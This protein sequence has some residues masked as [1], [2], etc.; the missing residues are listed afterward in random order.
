MVAAGIH[1]RRCHSNLGMFGIRIFK[2]YSAV[3]LDLLEELIWNYRMNSSIEQ[4]KRVKHFNHIMNRE[5][6]PTENCIP[7]MNTWLQCV[8]AKDN[9]CGEQKCKFFFGEWQNCHKYNSKV[10]AHNKQMADDRKGSAGTFN[11]LSGK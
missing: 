1:E 2:E 9:C 6:V 4:K 5:L 10:R 3:Q 7:Y 8:D 11:G